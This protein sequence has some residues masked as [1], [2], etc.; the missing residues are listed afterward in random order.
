MSAFMCMSSLFN[1]VFQTFK[2]KQRYGA[3]LNFGTVLPILCCFIHE[4]EIQKVRVLTK[5]NHTQNNNKMK[6]YEE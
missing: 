5:Q 3:K 2:T 4:G 6:C 1:V